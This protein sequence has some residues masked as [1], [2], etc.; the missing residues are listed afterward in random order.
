MLEK[1]AGITDLKGVDYTYI[2]PVLIEAIKELDAKI[3]D[4]ENQLGS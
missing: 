1:P 3:T 4:I 2:S